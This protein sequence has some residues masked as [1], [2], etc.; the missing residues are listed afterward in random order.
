MVYNLLSEE[1]RKS[2]DLILGDLRLLIGKDRI[3]VGEM[4]DLLQKLKSE[5]AKLYIK[6]LSSGSKPE[7]ALRE[8]F[9][10]GNSPLAKYL[11]RE[12]FPEV[13]FTHDEARGF[14]DY[15]IVDSDTKRTI[16]LELKALF[17]AKEETGKTRMPRELKEVSP[18]ILLLPH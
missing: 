9:L 6:S 12:L 16:R 11:F 14:I 1:E 3:S 17:E 2:L 7:Q 5:E 15:V 13:K 8:S 10:A 4:G 18:S